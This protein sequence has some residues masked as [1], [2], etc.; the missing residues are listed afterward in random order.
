MQALALR[1]PN[2]QLELLKGRL[3]DSFRKGLNLALTDQIDVE[4]S[5]GEMDSASRARSVLALL[6]MADPYLNEFLGNY[7]DKGAFTVAPSGGNPWRLWLYEADPWYDEATHTLYV[8]ASWTAGQAVDFLNE[9][10]HDVNTPMGKRFLAD[11][12]T[13]GIFNGKIGFEEYN[14]LLK[15][16]LAATAEQAEGLIREAISLGGPSGDLALAAWDAQ[17]EGIISATLTLLKNQA[18]ELALG[19]SLGTMLGAVKLAKW[20][21]ASRGTPNWREFEKLAFG[22]TPNKET[23]TL[24]WTG[25]SRSWGTRI[26]DDWVPSTGTIQEATKLNWHEV[27]LAHPT[28]QTWKQFTDKLQQAT[29]DGWLLRNDPRVKEVIWYGAEALPTTGRG[30]EL[31]RLLREN[32]IIYRVVEIPW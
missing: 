22:H 10:A 30:A 23:F 24:P 31:A 15:Q 32:G 16:G 5:I 25:H 8:P 28:S 18:N 13:S 21:N 17:N 1:A 27:N 19:A 3:N 26:P 20:M 14:S 9:H 7:I 4:S 11:L 29:Q 12:Q 6:A 2:R